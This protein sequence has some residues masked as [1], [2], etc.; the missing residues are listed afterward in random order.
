MREKYLGKISY[1]ISACL[2]VILYAV[3]DDS[4]IHRLLV[5]AV[6]F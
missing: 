5:T 4:M 6:I 3:M 1:A 2:N